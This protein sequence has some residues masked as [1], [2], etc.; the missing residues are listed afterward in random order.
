MAV[1]EIRKHKLKRPAIKKIKKNI[2]IKINPKTGKAEGFLFN[3]PKVVISNSG[4][5]GIGTT[6]PDRKL[7]ILDTSNPQLRLTYTN[8]SKG[9]DLQSDADSLLHITPVETGK[10][11]V[12][13]FNIDVPLLVVVLLI[14]IV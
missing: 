11:A 13:L 5:L 14:L 9:T 1:R 2:E 10:A 12:I 7:D 3:K 6:S 8:G 4:Y